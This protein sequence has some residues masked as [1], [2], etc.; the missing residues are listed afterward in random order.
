MLA[1]SSDLAEPDVLPDFE[2]PPEVNPRSSSQERVPSSG[3][4]VPLGSKTPPQPTSPPVGATPSVNVS[5]PDNLD[6][7][8][9][10]S[11][12]RSDSPMDVDEA[13][14]VEGPEPA[15]PPS[16]TS[17]TLGNIVP[18][19][20][21]L[22][23]VA[24][25]PES[26]NQRPTTMLDGMFCLFLSVSVQVTER[27]VLAPLA[28]SP[29]A[30]EPK[31][32]DAKSVNA[33][34]VALY[35]GRDGFFKRALPKEHVPPCPGRSRPQSHRCTLLTTLSLADIPSNAPESSAQAVQASAADV[36]KHDDVSSPKPALGAPTQSEALR[37]H[38]QQV[39]EVI[40]LIPYPSYEMQCLTYLSG[41]V[42][43]CS[44]EASLVVSCKHSGQ[45]N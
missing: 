42:I 43:R 32:Q 18:A 21:D 5:F 15:E 1:H 40:K 17:P 33:K 2:E 39:L 6:A 29:P 41:S 37:T 10:S 14:V 38:S 35:S 28:P 45:I 4:D 24:A 44:G 25:P 23:I 20:S 22:S 8:L 13:D 11:R 7:I 12:S 9:P 26:Q 30:S 27:N 31:M 36:A 3:P 19:L 34:R 16:G